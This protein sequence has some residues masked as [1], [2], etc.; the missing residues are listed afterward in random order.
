M[1]GASKESRVKFSR[2]FSALFLVATSAQTLANTQAGDIPPH[3]PQAFAACLQAL[4]TKAQQ[5]GL[6]DQSL[7]AID[8]LSYVPRVIEL[9]R[10]QPEFT[11]TFEGYFSKRINDWRVQ[12]GRKMF[13]EQGPLLKKLQREYGIPPQ[14]L[15]AF[16]GLET[17]FGAYK[18][19]MPVLDSLATLAC[20]AR[21]SEY[22]TGELLTALALA[23]RNKLQPD[24]LI[25]SWAGAMGH[26]QFMPSAYSKYA[27]DGDGDG[28]ADLIGSVPD[29][30]TSA[31]NFLMHLGWQRNERWGREV[32]LP[33]NFDFSQLGRDHK[34][35][36]AD[37][38]AKG[39]TLPSGKPLP[40]A[41]MKAALY[42]PAGH[43]GPAFIGYSNFD[44]I[45]RWNRSEFYAIAVGHLAD[46]INGAVALTV[47][48]P[49]QPVRS[50]AS[51]KA[52]QDKLNTLGFDAGKADGVL[53]AKS[54]A[55]IRAFQQSKGLIA[56]GFADDATFEALGLLHTE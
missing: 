50:R 31:A 8:K 43:K 20:D 24:A 40:V 38:A 22:F 30:L 41:D 32:A 13:K 14:Y 12:Q 10:N 44:V 28:R 21:R 6:G 7:A 16:W 18:G 54:L 17:N 33:K 5:Q 15:L 45:M 49:V 37:W 29:A 9:D 36:L 11:Q 46:R 47:A 48:P 56:D 52:L 23:E 51:L 1:A 19:K 34:L 39:V 55:A 3:D 4:H 26:T 27:K 53:G 2:I 35:P 42:L 25:G